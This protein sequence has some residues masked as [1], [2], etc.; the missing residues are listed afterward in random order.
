MVDKSS[1]GRA[2]SGHVGTRVRQFGDRQYE[3]DDEGREGKERLKKNSPLSFFG[4]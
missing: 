3:M 2:S 1:D 4:V